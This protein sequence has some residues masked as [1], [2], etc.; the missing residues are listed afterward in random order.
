[1]DRVCTNV[2]GTAL[3]HPLPAS[4]SRAHPA[5]PARLKVVQSNV[6]KSTLL[7]G[8]ILISALAVKPLLRATHNDYSSASA[9]STIFYWLFHVST[10]EL[11]PPNHADP[12]TPADLLALAARHRRYILQ[13]TA[14]AVTRDRQ[15]ARCT[16]SGRLPWHDGQDCFRREF[17]CSTVA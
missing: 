17:C 4:A 6:V 14:A 15:A 3:G 1:M 12:A 7:Q 2:T 9:T 8:V 16:S 10:A 5:S 11:A 13:W